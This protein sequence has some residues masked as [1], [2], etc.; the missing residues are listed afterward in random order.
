MESVWLERA[1]AVLLESPLSGRLPSLSGD[2][3]APHFPRASFTGGLQRLLFLLFSCLVSEDSGE[4]TGDWNTK[5]RPGTFSRS[6]VLLLT[7]AG[8]GVGLTR[9]SEKC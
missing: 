1:W 9:C 7:W 4:N 8:S 3:A 6:V 5:P 2:R